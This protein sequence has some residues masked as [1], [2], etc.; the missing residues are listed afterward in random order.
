MSF[1]FSVS[2]SDSYHFY[3]ANS[4]LE[5]FKVDGSNRKEAEK[6]WKVLTSLI[7]LWCYKNLAN[8]HH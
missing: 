4:E 7:R 5:L 1:F 8:Q 3:F 2:S 6:N